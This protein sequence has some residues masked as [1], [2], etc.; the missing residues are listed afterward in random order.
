MA[1]GMDTIPIFEHASDHNLAE[2]VC[3]CVHWYTPVEWLGC[4]HGDFEDKGIDFC[5]K[6]VKEHTPTDAYHRSVK[7]KEGKCGKYDDPPDDPSASTD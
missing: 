7:Q 2:S 3:S 5:G 6:D 1:E 4:L